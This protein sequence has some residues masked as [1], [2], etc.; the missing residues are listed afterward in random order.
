MNNLTLHIFDME[1]HE[2][3]VEVSL[4]DGRRVEVSGHSYDQEREFYIVM[5]AEVL[6]DTR[7]RLRL[8]W[9]GN[10]NTELI[11]LYRS[12][13]TAQDGQLRY[14]LVHSHW[15][16]NVEAWLSL[17]ERFMVL[18]HQLSYVIKKG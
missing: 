1:I 9:T 17:V 18:L 5:L 3:E 12:S 6:H 2:E 15:S 10:L 7:L 13:Y 8:R 4:E 11:G 14:S 16:R